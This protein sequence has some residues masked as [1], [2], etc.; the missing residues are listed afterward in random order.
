AWEIARPVEIVDVHI[1]N[2]SEGY[3]SNYILVNNF[4][5]TDRGR[6]A[7][8]ENNKSMLKEKYNIPKHHLDDRFSVSVWDFGDGYKKLPTGDVR[9]SLESSDL[10]CFDDMKVVENCIEKK[11]LLFIRKYDDRYV[12]S[13]GRSS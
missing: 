11:S 1:N 4:P 10:L 12:F 7:W 9:L 3:Y 5:I 13:M 2:S 8:W 6:I